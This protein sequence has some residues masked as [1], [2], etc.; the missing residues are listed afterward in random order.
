[1]DLLRFQIDWRRQEVAPVTVFPVPSG[2]VKQEDFPGL[3]TASLPQRCWSSDNKRIVFSTIWRSSQE[4]VLVDTESKE[5]K[6]LTGPGQLGSGLRLPKWEVLDVYDDI[7]VASASSP[8]I[9]PRLYFAKL[10]GSGEESRLEWVV[11]DE[12][13]AADKE[14][15]R[16]EFDWNVEVIRDP[17]GWCDFGVSRNE[18]KSGIALC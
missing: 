8:N 5:L 3:Y 14:F 4:I 16:D 6:R 1:M 13:A 17:V 9:C 11:V 7:I 2:D 15:E 18:L 10:P 12:G